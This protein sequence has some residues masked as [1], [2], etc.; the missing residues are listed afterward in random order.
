MGG[1]VLG[2]C[3]CFVSGGLYVTL[4]LPIVWSYFDRS[5]SST[6]ILYADEINRN[7]SDLRLSFF[8]T[9]GCNDKASLRYAVLISRTY[10]VSQLSKW[11][12]CVI[13]WHTYSRSSRYI[14]E[15]VEVHYIFDA[16][17]VNIK[18]FDCWARYL[19]DELRM[20]NRRTVKIRLS[21]SQTIISQKYHGH[22][23]IY[24]WLRCFI[25]FVD[26]SFTIWGHMSELCDSK[27]SIFCCVVLR[28][29]HKF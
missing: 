27:N 21:L 12:W 11:I 3:V 23:S 5:F 26:R 15:L 8:V 4:R 29:F 22:S 10:F 9:S 25:Y 28:S 2:W 16:I 19:L 20:Q 24:R 14:Q 18:C 13:F 17:Y 1:R 7:W 6:R